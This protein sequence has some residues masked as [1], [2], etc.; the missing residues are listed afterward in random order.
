M[1]SFLEVGAPFFY[2]GF[3]ISHFSFGIFNFEAML[4]MINAK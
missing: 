3:W 2:F 1:T 4:V